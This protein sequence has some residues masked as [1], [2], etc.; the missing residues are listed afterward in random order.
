MNKILFFLFRFV[1]QFQNRIVKS[2]K[3]NLPGSEFLIDTVNVADR[4]VCSEIV[5]KIWF[6]VVVSFTLIFVLSDIPLLIILR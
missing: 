4:L 3:V 6:A 5:D 1:I 2:V